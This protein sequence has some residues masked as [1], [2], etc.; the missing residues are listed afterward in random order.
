MGVAEALDPDGS[1][2]GRGLN[3]GAD[4]DAGRDR[5]AVAHYIDVV[6]WYPAGERA[7]VD[8]HDRISPH[9]EH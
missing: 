1:F 4:C 7:A 9:R 8:P 5:G 2:V 6:L 3:I